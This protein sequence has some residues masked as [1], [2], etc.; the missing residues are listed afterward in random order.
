MTSLITFIGDRLNEDEHLAKA[1]GHPTWGWSKFRDHSAFGYDMIE[2]DG[3]RKAGY[4]IA[5]IWDGI[6]EEQAE[7]IVR[8]DPDRTLR[9][10]DA[11]R[12]MLTDL[13]KLTDEADSAISGEWA[14]NLGSTRLL[15]ALLALPYA[16]HADYR[17]E[18][19]P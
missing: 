9:E 14:E 15:L 16:W 1:A 17:E 2:P 12:R 7:Y 5:A 19:R 10:I 8:N 6:H 4:C 18:W 11:K 13:K 3:T